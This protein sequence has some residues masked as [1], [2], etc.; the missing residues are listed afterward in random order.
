M[1]TDPIKR[2]VTT[3]ENMGVCNRRT[4]FT[5][6]YIPN[7]LY[8]RSKSITPNGELDNAY[9]MFHLLASAVVKIQI[10]PRTDCRGMFL[11][12]TY[13]SS[14]LHTAEE[15]AL[16]ESLSDVM[17]CFGSPTINAPWLAFSF[18]LKCDSASV[19]PML[20]HR[21]TTCLP[22]NAVNCLVYGTISLRPF[23][24]GKVRLSGV[25]TMKSLP[26]VLCAVDLKKLCSLKHIT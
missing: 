19:W 24:Y 17:S 16:F 13:S 12:E 18:I 9:I 8:V 20:I 3:F 5:R 11:D 6:F 25:R 26:S 4:P 2:K 14:H 7:T 1:S 10:C 15:L 22:E 21:D 23:K